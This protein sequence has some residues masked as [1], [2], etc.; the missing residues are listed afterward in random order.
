MFTIKSS[1]TP[2]VINPTSRMGHVH[3][4]VADP[5]RQIALYQDT[6]RSRLPR[7]VIPTEEI[8]EGILV[9]DPSAAAAVLTA[10]NHGEGVA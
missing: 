3:L 2:F 9:R 8:E 7:R 10:V 1:E 6:L 5:E 4:T